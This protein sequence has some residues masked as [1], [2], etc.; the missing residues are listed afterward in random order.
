MLPEDQLKISILR[1]HFTL[2]NQGKKKEEKKVEVLNVNEKKK[3]FNNNKN[4]DKKCFKCGYQGHISTE[5]RTSQKKIDEYKKLREEEKEKESQQNKPK[6][7]YQSKQ[8]QKQNSFKKK[9]HS[10]NVETALSATTNQQN[11]DQ[12]WYID[13]GCT[14]H[15]KNDETKL[16]NKT[17][18][19]TKVIGSIN[20]ES[21]EVTVKGECVVICELND[22]LKRVRLMNVLFVPH[23]RR[24]LLSVRS[25]CENGAKAE[26]WKDRC[27]VTVNDELVMTAKKDKTGLYVVEEDGAVVNDYVEEEKE[28][29][30]VNNVKDMKKKEELLML[31]INALAT[32][33]SI[34]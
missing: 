30:E 11:K 19:N 14:Q 26:F 2:E 33:Q 7:N 9:E 13:S 15:M 3:Q 34:K 16:Q 22:E 12:R 31:C 18:T 23:L 24:N 29:E 32:Y 25:L 4:K 6:T 10:S 20:K 28:D 5:C 27:F 8:E 1:Q 21:D 17:Q